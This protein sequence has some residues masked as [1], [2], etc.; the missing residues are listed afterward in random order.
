M[1]DALPTVFV[2]GLLCSARLY[3]PQIPVLWGFGPIMVADHT[4]DDDVAALVDRILADAPP[5]FALIGLSMGGY[6]ALE[7]MRQ[8]PNRVTK[9]AL[10]DT[11]ARPDTPEQSERRQRLIGGG[12][13]IVTF[14]LAG[15]ADRLA[16][17]AMSWTGLSSKQTTALG[18]GVSA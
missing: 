11:T 5:R 18:S 6:V 2:P 16:H 1:A 3:G 14:V 4:R 15:A 17:L 13:A 8:A 9:L 7:V 12:L 10:L